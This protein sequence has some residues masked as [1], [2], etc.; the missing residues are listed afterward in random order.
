VAGPDAVAGS[1]LLRQMA[2][3]VD[4]P[5]RVVLFSGGP[6]LDRGAA[7]FLCRLER[8]P[9]IQLLAAF[10]QSESQSLRGVLADRWRRRGLLAG[11]VLL[12]EWA[13]QAGR[14]LN[15]PRAELAL[16]RQVAHL[17][18]RIHY[19]PD[20]HAAGVL[21]QI[22]ALQPDL[23]LAYGSPILRPDLFEI[24]HFGTLGIHHGKVPE[25]RGKK[26]T[27][28]AMYNGE[29]TAGVTVQKISTGLDRGHVVRQGEVPI[30]RR[31]LG[32][33]SQDLE[34]LG[35]EQFLGAILDV[36]NGQA[37]Y[38]PQAGPTRKL[39]RDPK[40]RDLLVFWWRRGRAYFRLGEGR[41]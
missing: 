28:W 18:D 12:A 24:P 30:G 26:T 23:G 11:P 33:V 1:P 37:T 19:V 10:C 21:E 9:D 31:S 13:S 2:V 22:H 14:L 29:A 27:F 39:Y 20:I 40:L 38:Q 25:Y 41:P 34:V 32:R 36:K 7:Q 5:I 4:R 35:I 3:G 16:R 8:H 17:A 15:Q 6:T